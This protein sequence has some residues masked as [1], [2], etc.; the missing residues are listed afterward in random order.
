MPKGFQWDEVPPPL[1]EYLCICCTSWATMVSEMPGQA[2][3]VVDGP[4]Q[5][6]D[7]PQVASALLAL[8]LQLSKERRNNRR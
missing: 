4:A 3:S 7:G 1:R 6:H 2:S 8:L 5:L